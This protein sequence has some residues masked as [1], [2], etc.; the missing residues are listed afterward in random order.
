MPF[1]AKRNNYMQDSGSYLELFGDRNCAYSE[2]IL[3]HFIK[4][5]LH[6]IS[7]VCRMHCWVGTMFCNTC[8][9]RNVKNHVVQQR[10]CFDLHKLNVQRSKP[11][12]FNNIIKQYKYQIELQPVHNLTQPEINIRLQ[13]QMFKDAISAS[14]L[15]RTSALKPHRHAP[16]T[17]S[18]W[19]RCNI[20]LQSM[21]NAY[22]PTTAKL[23]M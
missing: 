14:C 13:K 7:L 17:A 18:P 16:S 8:W 1:L 11:N 22:F 19:I 6:A 5:P 20:F 3:A 23:V 10:V 9:F 2:F 15:R 12:V 21:C 4:Q